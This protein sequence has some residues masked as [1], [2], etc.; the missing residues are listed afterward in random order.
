[1]IKYIFLI[2]LLINV[3]TIIS[4]K[5]CNNNKYK[6]QFI[7]DSNIIYLTSPDDMDITTIITTCCRNNVPKI[8]QIKA[9]LFSL[10]LYLP[11][12]SFNL[13]IVFDGAEINDSYIIDNKC[14]DFCNADLY[15]IY[16]ENVKQFV[17]SDFPISWTRFIE[18]PYRKCLRD[19][20]KAGI[21]ACDTEFINI[22]QED[23]Q[24]IKP[25]DIKQII[26]IIKVNSDIDII[27]YSYKSND[28]HEEHMKSI[29]IEN[30]LLKEIKE[31]GKLNFSRA[32]GFSDQNHI[33]TKTFY[34]DTIFKNTNNG[35][36]MEHD[37]LCELGK[38]IP[39]TI[40]MI[41]DYDGGWYIDHLDGR[42]AD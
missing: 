36:F 25:F 38:N 20:L 15:K 4:L 18:L 30:E 8:D 24:I 41:D 40:W 17:H 3:I 11:L 9:T 16:I 5:L 2:I 23:L 12:A 22:M 33:S 26:N 13:I 32:N 28:S 1:M 6:K 14:Q 21:D 31:I 35:N 27:R 34:K 37:L 7:I 29:C 19:S 10:K 42:Y 39:R